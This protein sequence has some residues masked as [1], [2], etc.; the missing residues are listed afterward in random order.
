[1]L[2]PIGLGVSDHPLSRVMTSD[3]LAHTFSKHE[4]AFSPH[5]VHELCQKSPSKIRG[6]REG[7]VLVDPPAVRLA[8]IKIKILTHDISNS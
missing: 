3:V 6:R 4:S 1:V 8:P 5:D 2:E 7:R